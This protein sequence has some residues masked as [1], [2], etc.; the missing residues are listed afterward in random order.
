MRLLAITAVLAIC[1]TIFANQVLAAAVVSTSYLGFSKAPA[2]DPSSSPRNSTTVH[3]TADPAWD[4]ALTSGGNLWAGMHSSDRKASFLFRTDPH[5]REPTIQ[6]VQS[7]HQRDLSPLFE[8]WGYSET[9][10]RRI[11]ADCDF[12]AYHG[13]KRAFAELG[14]DTR[15]SG[16]GGANQCVQLEHKDGRK[17]IRGKDGKMPSVREQ[18]YVDESCGKEY[19]VCSDPRLQQ[20]LTPTSTSTIRP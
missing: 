16:K 11:D 2:P 7:P 12:D 19:R 10:A 4:T 14:V 18:K 8:K 9:E 3:A 17:V 1:T 20:P 15:S 13:F 5:Q 6:T